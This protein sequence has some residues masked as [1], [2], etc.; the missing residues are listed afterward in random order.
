FAI[1]LLIALSGVAFL[2]YW[3]ALMLLGVGWNFLFLTGTNLLALG[4]RSSERFRVQSFNDFMT[5]SVQALVSLG[6]G[7]FLYLFGWQALLWFGGLLV[8]A[9]VTLLLRT[10]AFESSTIGRRALPRVT[11]IDKEGL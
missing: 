3:T 7:W 11:T 6:S 4:H 8:L 5:F 9:F 2:H 10:R 1:T